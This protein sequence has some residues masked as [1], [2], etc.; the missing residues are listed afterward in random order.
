MR[1]YGTGHF[2]IELVE[3]TNNPNEREIYWIEQYN[4]YGSNGYNATKGGDGKAYI[5]FEYAKKRYE[6]VQNLAL[7]SKEMNIDTKHL[8]EVLREMGVKTLT[9]IEVNQRDRSK[10]VNQ[11]DK[12]GNFI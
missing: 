4:S 9:S 12:Q 7:V 6:E 8:G 3:E 10:I 1:K 11:Y 5:D 2:H